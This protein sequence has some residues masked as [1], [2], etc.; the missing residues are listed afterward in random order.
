MNSPCL[1]PSDKESHLNEER[2]KMKSI[3]IFALIV[4]HPSLVLAQAPDSKTYAL[5]N[6]PGF[7]KRCRKIALV[8]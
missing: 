6:R 1:R 2:F 5:S 3:L 4:T 7:T 8:P